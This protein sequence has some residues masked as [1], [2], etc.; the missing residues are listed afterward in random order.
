M[1]VVIGEVITRDG[2]AAQSYWHQAPLRRVGPFSIVDER[3]DHELRRR[4]FS[5]NALAARTTQAPWIGINRDHDP[6]QTIGHL[7]HLE[8]SR[9]GALWGVGILAR[10]PEVSG[11]LYFSPETES[12]RGPEDLEIV[13]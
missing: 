12:G 6:P 1:A 2:I 10:E 3:P 9:S 4:H 8:L 7:E 11:P 5:L 13:P